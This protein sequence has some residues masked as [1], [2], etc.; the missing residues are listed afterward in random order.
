M[1]RPVLNSCNAK[2]FLQ[3][4][5]ELSPFRNKPWLPIPPLNDSTDQYLPG[6]F[7]STQMY[8]PPVGN[9]AYGGFSGFKG[10]TETGLDFD[11]DLNQLLNLAPAITS[12]EALTQQAA[13]HDIIV[14]LNQ[15][16]SGPSVLPST[17][18]NM[19]PMPP[20][21][22]LYH[23]TQS[24]AVPCAPTAPTVQTSTCSVLIPSVTAQ[25]A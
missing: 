9:Q 4:R 12:P 16:T 13:M 18:P 10:T 6:A 22:P 23:A 25:Y 24:I 7:D 17:M 21:I 3:A 8:Q 2:Y 19:P 5:K 11:F 14:T 1:C 15:V 20:P